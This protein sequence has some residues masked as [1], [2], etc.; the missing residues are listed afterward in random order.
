MKGDTE[1]ASSI[2]VLDKIAKVK[3]YFLKVDKEFHPE[4]YEKA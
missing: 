1:D 4:K 3:Q 2:N